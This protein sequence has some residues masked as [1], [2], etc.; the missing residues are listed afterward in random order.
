MRWAT[1]CCGRTIVALT[2]FGMVL[3]S[4]G[5]FAQD[6][7]PTHALRLIVP[8]PPGQSGDTVARLV[9]QKMA[10]TLGQT[11]VVEN[12]SG[13]AAIIGMNT[14]KAAAPDGY[15]LIYA[16]TGPLAINPALY[17]KLPYDARKDFTAVGLVN[18]A[19]Q[20]LVINPKVSAQTVP[21]LLAYLAVDPQ[22]H[23]YGSGGVG[24]TNHLTMEMFKLK[25]GLAMT[26]IPY[27]GDA[28]A[29]NALMAGTL[30]SCSFRPRWPR[31]WSRRAGFVP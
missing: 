8:Y 29:V 25:T 11:I 23:N 20:L 27:T 28:A 9:A 10:Q 12:K 14:L 7:F 5:T 1:L 4:S 16:S 2:I 3:A 30:R 13:A 19:P 24:F 22:K 17:D 31:L 18:S 21:E 15:T 6:T 26:H